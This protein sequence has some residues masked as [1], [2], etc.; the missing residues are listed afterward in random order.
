MWNFIIALPVFPWILIVFQT[1]VSLHS[2]WKFIALFF[3][4][5]TGL[6]LILKVRLDNKFDQSEIPRCLSRELALYTNNMCS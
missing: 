3:N 5:S 4:E 1:S 2:T 6:F